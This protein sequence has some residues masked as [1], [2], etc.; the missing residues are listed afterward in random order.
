[1]QLLVET[2]ARKAGGKDTYLPFAIRKAVVAAKMPEGELYTSVTVTESTE[3]SLTADVEIFSAADGKIAVRLEGASCRKVDPD[4]G[5]AR[6]EG[7]QCLYSIDWSAVETDGGSGEGQII[8][9]SPR[10][11]ELGKL[12]GLGKDRCSVMASVKDALDAIAEEGCAAIV[13]DASGSD[14]DALESALLLTQGVFSL[15]GDAPQVIFA[16]SGATPA[17][18]SAETHDPTHA[19]V[20]GFA[21]SARLEN[22]DVKLSCLDLDSDSAAEALAAL[23]DAE[24]EVSSR[25]GRVLGARLA[26]SAVAPTRP[27]RLRMAQRGSLMNLRPVP[28]S[29][30]PQVKDDEMEVRVQAI[31]MNFRDVLNVMG[32]YPGDPGDPGLDCSGTVINV[33]ANCKLNEVR[34]GDDAFGIVWGCLKTYGACKEQLLVKKPEGWSHEDA[35]ALPT[36]YTTVDV[37]FAELIKLKKG[38]RVLIHAATGGVGLVAVQ[39]AMRLGAI[40]YATAGKD[41]KQQFLRDMGVKYIATTRDG[42]KFEQDMKKLLGSDKLDACLNSMSHDDYIGRSLSML[43]EGGRFVEIGKRDIWTTEQVKE[44]YPTVD[45]HIEAIDHVCE[46]EPDRYHGLLRRLE[47]ELS[48][49]AW[50]P[51]PVVSFRGLEQGV[52]SLQCLQR[53]AHIGKVV[54]NVPLRMGLRP[55]ATYVLSGGMGA[56]GVVTAQVMSEEGAKSLVLMSRG[57]KAGAEVQKEWEWLQASSVQVEAFRCDVGGKDSVKLLQKRFKQD[58]KRPVAGILHLAGILDDGMVPALSRANF[59]NAYGPKVRGAEYLR[60][61]AKGSKLDFFALYSST[62]ALLG[63]AGQA[64]YSA[65][66]TMLDAFATNWRLKGEAAQSVQWG[67]WLSVGMA[68]QNNSFKALKLGGIPNELGLSVLSA[69]IASP[70]PVTMVGC[71][72]VQWPSYLKQFAR[73]PKYFE[74]FR[75]EAG[76]GAG[77]VAIGKAAEKFLNAED[78]I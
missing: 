71:A 28:Q 59:E 77:G 7:A 64:N 50:K 21:R 23:L 65:A 40:V 6:D 60:E 69:A 11:E 76:A 55:D 61:A 2:A 46:F 74:N 34:C 10:G 72:L 27:L 33:G 35:A 31:G 32:L 78:I 57:G 19:G 42:A 53:A 67:P 4:A 41:D 24:T 38:E 63:A 25:Q 29:Q 70:G 39:Y 43:R 3:T 5:G 17:E 16:T 47:A 49:G 22:P 52:A 62:A 56:L 36:V 37:A 1:M 54:L 58:A 45:Y 20:W 8:V 44:K 12:L 66:N 51:L 48:G 13:L 26:R 15:G 73:T 18:A 9:V 68:A 30:R 14:V 75:G